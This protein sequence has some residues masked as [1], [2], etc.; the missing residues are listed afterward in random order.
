MTCPV[1]VRVQF[2]YLLINLWT[3]SVS[4]SPE[5]VTRGLERARAL[6]IVWHALHVYIPHANTVHMS[7]QGLSGTSVGPHTTFLSQSQESTTVAG[8]GLGHLPQHA[9]IL[10]I[11]DSH[12]I[13]PAKPGTDD[14]QVA[15][16]E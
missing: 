16:K 12:K 8:R 7:H 15:A 1:H 2:L 13:P 11:L 14:N 6:G 3:H 10:R 9:A 5:E 4:V